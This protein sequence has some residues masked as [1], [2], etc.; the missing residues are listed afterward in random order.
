MEDNTNITNSTIENVRYECKENKSVFNTVLGKISNVFG[1]L[2]YQ[3]LVVLD[4]SQKKS[5][6]VAFKNLADWLIT[7]KRSV[8]LEA[9]ISLEDKKTICYVLSISTTILE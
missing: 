8:F 9:D 1:G 6:I 5:D 7:N 4:E 3:E 2:D